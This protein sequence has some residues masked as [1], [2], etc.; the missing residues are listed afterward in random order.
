MTDPRPNHIPGPNGLPPAALRGLTGW[1]VWRFEQQPGELKPRKVPYYVQGGRRQG[2]QGAPEDRAK[3]TTFVAARDAAE[4]KGFSGVGLA[5]MPE[6]DLVALDVDHCIEVGGDT[7]S[8][9]LAIIGLTYAEISPS[10]TGIRA[11]FKGD[12]G[13]HKSPRDAEHTYGAEVFS[14][15]GFVTVTGNHC[16]MTT[17]LALEDIIAPVSEALVDFCTSRFGPNRPQSVANDDFM[18]GHE[19]PVGLS[20]QE[21]ACYL[22]DLDASM[23]RDYWIRV[24]MAVHHETGGGG[25]DLWDEWSAGGHQYPGSEALQAQWGSFDRGRS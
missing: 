4:R 14:S 21:I 23:G 2:K 6:F 1:L 20:D 13:N 15:S 18:A 22:S 3:L 5:L 12:L 24:G 11:F 9:L 17:M 10:G 19:P 7:P 8:E 16:S 25:F